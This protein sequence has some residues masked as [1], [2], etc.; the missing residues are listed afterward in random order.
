MLLKRPL[1]GFSVSLIICSALGEN[2]NTKSSNTLQQGQAQWRE[3]PI[4]LIGITSLETHLA[5]K[6]SSVLHCSVT[7]YSVESELFCLTKESECFIAPRG[8]H[9]DEPKTADYKVKYRCYKYTEEACEDEESVEREEI[10]TS[11]T[12]EATVAP[13]VP[14][15]PVPR[16]GDDHGQF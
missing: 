10:V 6:E 8:I 9:S 15:V 11:A 13:E 7:A 16:Y 1:I 3:H 4:D 5:F 12:I 14:V 2:C